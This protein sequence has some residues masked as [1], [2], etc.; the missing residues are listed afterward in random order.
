MARPKPLIDRLTTAQWSAIEDWCQHGGT[1]VVSLGK[2]AT[3]M[4][5]DAP[6]ARILPGP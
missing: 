2:Y 1:L 4:A 3:E 5:S 6:L